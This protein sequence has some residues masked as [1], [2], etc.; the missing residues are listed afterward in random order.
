MKK[1]QNMSY[2]II[3]LIIGSLFSF[4]SAVANQPIKLII[5]NKE[6]INASPQIID[7][8]VYVPIRVIS[9][10]LGAN[11]EWD[12]KNRVVRVIGEGF[13]NT[14]SV[15]SDQDSIKETT[16]K[17]LKAIEK[18]GEVYF[19]LSQYI[20]NIRMSNP[21]NYI[22]KNDKDNIYELY[23]NG[24]KHTFSKVKEIGIIHDDNIYVN[25]KNYIEY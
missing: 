16:F 18:N 21:Q 14:P 13:K 4:N 15:N 5:N 1:F 20:T 10:N 11:V 12:G 22:T 24:N 25:V 19:L 17:G 23:V 8:R 7:D 3:G 9:E 2:L 6:I